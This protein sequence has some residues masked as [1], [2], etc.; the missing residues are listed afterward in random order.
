MY[1]IPPRGLELVLGTPLRPNQKDTIVMS[2][3]GYFQL[4]ANPGMWFLQL[5]RNSRSSE[6]F[7]IVDLDNFETKLDHQ[8]VIVS[9]FEGAFVPLRV[10]K[11][12]GKENEQLLTENPD[13]VE[14]EDHDVWS[15][16]KGYC[17][18]TLCLMNVTACGATMNL[19]NQ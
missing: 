6:L 14:V 4:K 17:T 11:K 18:C 8:E 5:K 12:Q 10:R 7:N 1:S 9:D 19:Q 13:V 16:F 15:S 2:N 3:L